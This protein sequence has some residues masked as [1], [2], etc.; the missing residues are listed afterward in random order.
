MEP[1]RNLHTFGE[2]PENAPLSG[3]ASV[4]TGQAEIASR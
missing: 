2:F 4:A 3:A 1:A